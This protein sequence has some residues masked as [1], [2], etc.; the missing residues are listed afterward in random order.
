MVFSDTATKLG[1]VQDID[2]L[3]FGNSVDTSPYLIADKVR[4]VNNR[5]D[6]TVSLIMKS[7]ARWKWDDDNQTDQPIGTI[8]LV[9]EQAEYEL[10]GATYLKILRVE[11][12]DNNGNYQLVKPIDEK[13]VQNQS[14]TEFLKTPGMP[15]V[16]DKN[17]EYIWLYPK[18]SSAL[19]T[20]SSGLKIYYQR[21]PSYF[22]AADTTKSPGFNPLYHKILSMGAAI[23]YAIPNG[24]TDKMAMLIP[25]LTTMQNE[26]ATFYADRAGDEKTRMTTRGE[27]YGGGSGYGVSDVR[28]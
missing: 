27:D 6:E 12:L 16:Y 2:Y 23:D 5:L 11:V 13:N 15:R 14:L 8:N 9:S 4:N 19:T 25:L 28:I 26:M 1:L 7:D 3:L 22:T 21:L 18:P 10:A 24:L 17:G 20:L